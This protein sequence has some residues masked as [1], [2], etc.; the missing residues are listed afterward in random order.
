MPTLTLAHTLKY[1]GFGDDN[2]YVVL[3][4]GRVVGRIMLHPKGPDNRRWFWTITAGDM[5]PTVDNR[6]Y[7]A[8][9]EEAMATHV[10]TRM[11]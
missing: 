7:S 8:N 5:T 10:T 11:P 1:F 6:G 2:D 9:R 4:G 3:D